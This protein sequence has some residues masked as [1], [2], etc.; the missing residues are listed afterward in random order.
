VLRDEPGASAAQP[1]TSAFP[2]IRAVSRV[3]LPSRGL[4]PSASRARAWRTHDVGSRPH[5]QFTLVAPFQ[6]CAATGPGGLTSVDQ[7]S[8]ESWVSE[9][10]QVDRWRALRRQ[11]ASSPGAL[12]HARMHSI[13]IG[14][15]IL[16][17]NASELLDFLEA[18]DSPEA[19]GV[20]DFEHPERLEAA[21]DEA[22]RLLHNFVASVT[23]LID[24]TRNLMS[25]YV[26]EDALR[27]SYQARVKETFT[28]G[29]PPFMKDL[30]NYTL[31]YRL[32][33]SSARMS[34]GVDH[35][36]D[37]L[38][39]SILLHRDDLLSWKRWTAPAR[40]YLRQAPPHLDLTELVREYLRTVASLYDWLIPELNR[41]HAG[42]IEA[43]N[44]L[45]GAQD[46]LL[47]IPKTPSDPAEGAWSPVASDN[48][49]EDLSV[50][51][52]T[53]PLTDR[54]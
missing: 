4:V 27:C 15:G 37:R 44:A 7:P 17:R 26:E 8:R 38:N 49:I 22:T 45:V 9:G 6:I 23:S 31:H 36:A 24:H 5:R 18:L 42:E 46:Q 21:M 3:V 48:H 50:Q 47:G 40:A 28:T 12:A 10:D 25:E 19:L 41:K 11:I 35:P 30:R 52:R 54:K 13:V 32:P 39:V 20:W 2:T 14:C 29:L 43:T 1:S 16:D 51:S 33:A 34:F 53:K